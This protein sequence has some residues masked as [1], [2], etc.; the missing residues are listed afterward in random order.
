MRHVS[1]QLVAVFT[2]LAAATALG[3][4]VTRVGI[5]N[6]VMGEDGRSLAGTT[7][8]WKSEWWE[9]DTYTALRWTPETG[10]VVKHTIHSD[11]GMMV[12]DGSQDMSTLYLTINEGTDWIYS[13]LYQL[14][15]GSK[16]NV[17]SSGLSVRSGG[18]SADGST[19]AFRTNFY[20]AAPSQASVWR[21]GIGYESI[22]QEL[23]VSSLTSDGSMALVTGSVFG[24][25]TRSFLWRRGAGLTPLSLPGDATAMSRN[26]TWFVGST[27]V[28]GQTYLYRWSAA[29]GAELF[30]APKG[31]VV[32]EP[33]NDGRTFLVRVGNLSNMWHDGEFLSVEGY[34]AKFGIGLG[35]VDVSNP[36]FLSADGWSIAGPSA[37][38]TFIAIIPS[39]GSSIV[40]AAWAVMMCSRRRRRVVHR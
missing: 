32:T 36:T 19:I 9:Q 16:S 5:S 37:G 20:E 26:G 28:N 23:G 30:A 7:V 25:D 4:S 35:G 6:A 17:I 15:D 18:V 21:S 1:V 39:P 12:V 8:K 40:P 2:S 31:V 34:L 24:H 22:G 38:G 3:Q 14:K 10:L 11:R 13:R 33:T 29:T 27:V